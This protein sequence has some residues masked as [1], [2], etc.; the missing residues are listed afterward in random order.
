MPLRITTRPVRLTHASRF[1]LGGNPARH[2]PGAGHLNAPLRHVSM[3]HSRPAQPVAC[4]MMTGIFSQANASRPRNA[5]FVR[6]SL[7]H[8]RARVVRRSCRRGTKFAEASTPTP[9]HPESR[10]EVAGLASAAARI[11]RSRPGPKWFTTHEIHDPKGRE[12]F[13]KQHVPDGVMLL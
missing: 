12:P 10:G 7:W 1:C 2:R 9:M 13:C 4:L 6:Q 8:S 3:W 5:A 11:G